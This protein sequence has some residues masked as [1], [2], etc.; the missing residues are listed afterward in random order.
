[1]AAPRGPTSGPRA[2]QRHHFLGGN[3]LKRSQI[4]YD[5][6]A[7]LAMFHG[8]RNLFTPERMGALQ[9]FGQRSDLPIFVVGM[10]RSGT[11]L[12]EQILASHPQAFGGGELELLPGWWRDA[13][14]ET[15]SRSRSRGSAPPASAIWRPSTSLVSGASRRGMR[16][17][18]IRR[19]RILLSLASSI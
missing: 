4:G 7:T 12:V 14:T 5:E 18:L 9:G 10:P 15:V 3:A 8:I 13:A 1:M 6:A 2:N 11:T 17:S 19:R 16:A